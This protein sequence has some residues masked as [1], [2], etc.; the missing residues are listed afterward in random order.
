MAGPRVAVAANL[1][2]PME[3]IV[4]QYRAETGNQ[5]VLIPGASGSLATQIINGAPYQM[6]LSANEAYAQSL[7]EDGIAAEAP[8]PLIEG[9]LLLWR[10]Y[11]LPPLE[12]SQI[13][14]NTKIAIANPEL[15]PYGKAAQDYLQESGLWSSIQSNLV[16]G[17][18]VGQVNQYIKSG[19]VDYA[20][21]APAVR[22]M[23]DRFAKDKWE[24]IPHT[25]NLAHPLLMLRLADEATRAFG[26]Y[27]QS[28]AALSIFREYGYQISQ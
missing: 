21:T 20:F 15:A 18:S 16:Q 1:L 7:Y 12:K 14:E 8:I 13:N 24:I 17:K 28:E 6:F 5:I 25:S 23:N 9:R 11:G 26:A 27:L 2:A 3:A 22:Y 4:K 10:K 19:I